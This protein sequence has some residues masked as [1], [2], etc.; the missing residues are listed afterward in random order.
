[1]LLSLLLQS[2]IANAVP[3]QLTQ[4]GRMVD[5]SGLPVDG[6]QIVIFRIYDDHTSGTKLWDETLTV[7]FNNGYYAT[8]LGVDTS[9]PLDSE[10]LSLYPLYL[11]LQLN[12]NP[13]M[14]PR[15]EVNS[16]PYAQMMS[17]LK[18]YKR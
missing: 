16:A 8:V 2:P 18:H 13:P 7:Q 17:W 6:A 5:S 11:E 14:L 4:Q 9:N 1:M 10:V 12:S 15:Q 3:L